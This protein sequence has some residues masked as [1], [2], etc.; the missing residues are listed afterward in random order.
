LPRDPDAALARALGGRRYD[1]P[2]SDADNAFLRRLGDPEDLSE[3]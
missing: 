3:D 1:D 2:G